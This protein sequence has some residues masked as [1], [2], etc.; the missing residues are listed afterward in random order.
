MFKRFGQVLMIVAVLAATGTHWAIL[1]SV[2]WT[3]MLAHNLQTTSAREA[4]VET[5]DGKHPCC[6]CKAIAAGKKSEKKK[7]FVASWKQLEFIS[8][9]S[10]L[11]FRSPESFTLLPELC[12]TWNTMTQKPPVP[13]PRAA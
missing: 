2:A 13:P 10:S 5:F 8:S 9:N 4:V 11:T 7:E 3:S 12:V 1:Q 6:L